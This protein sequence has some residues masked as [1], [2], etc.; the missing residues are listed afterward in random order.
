VDQW[1]YVGGNLY[2]KAKNY[3]EELNGR[4]EPTNV[5]RDQKYGA[6]LKLA[7]VVDRDY[8]TTLFA[9]PGFKTFT[10][11]NLWAEKN[12]DPNYETFDEWL[13]RKTDDPG[14]LTK[15]DIEKY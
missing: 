15:S 5:V 4:M 8:S 1:A 10:E 11:A 3:Y 6:A 12:K 13:A 14:T 7:D 9:G 2:D